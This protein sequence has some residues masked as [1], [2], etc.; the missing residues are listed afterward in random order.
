MVVNLRTDV[1]VN[2]AVSDV[3]AAGNV[4]Y[5]VK[6]VAVHAETEFAERSCRRDG[7]VSVRGYAGVH[8]HENVLH[9][10][11]CRGFCVKQFEFVETVYDKI[12]YTVG[13]SFVDFLFRLVIAVEKHLFISAPAD[14]TRYSSPPET[15][16]NQSPSFA[17]I[18]AVATV[19]NALFANATAPSP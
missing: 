13:K 19:A 3:F 9:H 4:A 1:H 5:H 12:S 17:A 18:L 2:T 11:E 14:L 10:S 7:F 16:S 15:T 8:S 6:S